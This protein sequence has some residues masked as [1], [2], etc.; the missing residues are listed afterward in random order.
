MSTVDVVKNLYD[1]FGKGD[2]PAVLGAMDPNIEWRE[3]ESN[4]YKMDGQAWV[5]PDAITQNLFMKLMADWEGF[6]VTPKSYHDA[7]DSV[8]VEGRYTAKHN[9]T[10]KHLDV[11]FCHVWKGATD[12]VTSFQQYTDTAK[13]QEAAGVR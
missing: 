12:K 13:L 3:A 1:A 9:A 10:G 5:G 4:P 7:G 11:Q 8:V 2:V 6:T